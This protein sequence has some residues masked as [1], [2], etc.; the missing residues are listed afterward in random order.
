MASIRCAEQ[1]LAELVTRHEPLRTVFVAVNGEPRPGVCTG[2]PYL[3][4]SISAPE[5]TQRAMTKRSE[6]ALP[7]RSTLRPGGGAAGPLRLV[8]ASMAR[9][10][11]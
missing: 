6:S 10:I 3:Q 1:V 5:I 4:R 2:G 11:C 7:S 8:A 9:M